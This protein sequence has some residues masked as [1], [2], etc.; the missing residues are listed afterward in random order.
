MIKTNVQCA[1]RLLSPWHSESRRVFHWRRTFQSLAI[2]ISAHLILITNFVCQF[3]ITVAVA[4]FNQGNLTCIA[5]SF[6]VTTNYSRIWIVQWLQLGWYACIWSCFCLEDEFHNK[7]LLTCSNASNHSDFF[8][9]V[10]GYTSYLSPKSDFQ[11]VFA[12]CWS[13]SF[14]SAVSLSTNFLRYSLR[15]A[16]KSICIFLSTSSKIPSRW[17]GMLQMMHLP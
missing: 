14:F 4:S 10:L 9:L 6:W 11:S 12:S 13:C 2:A 17:N 7:F 1:R 8:L 15:F 3:C 16:I 5:V